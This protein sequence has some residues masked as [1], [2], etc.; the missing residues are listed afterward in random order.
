[1]LGA[2]RAGR[3]VNKVETELLTPFGL[4][5]LTPR[6]PAY[7]PTYIG[8]PFDRDA[9]YH[10]GTVWGWLIGPFVD[11][12][13][14]VYSN[15]SET[16]KRVEEIL[17]GFRDHLNDAMIGQISEIFDADPPHTA[18]GCAAQAWSVAELLRI[19]ARKE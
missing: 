11:A 9:A 17:A 19:T 12:Y 3:V 4:R 2:D 10:Q 1:M 18:R 16:E 7:V 15:G 14:R 8:S 5:S 13:R 6:D